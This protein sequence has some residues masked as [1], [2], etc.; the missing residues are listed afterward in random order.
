MYIRTFVPLVLMTV[1]LAVLPQQKAPTF[2]GAALYRAHCASC[3]GT[4][5]RGDGPVAEFLK[6]PPADLTQ[7]ASHDRGAF[8]AAQVQRVID[9][10]QLVRTHGDAKMP[11]WGDVFS[12]SLTHEDEAAVRQKIE[13]LVNY[14][15]SIQERHARTE[16][17]NLPQGCEISRTVPVSGATTS[18][19]SGV[20]AGA[21]GRR[22]LARRMPS[23]VVTTGS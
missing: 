5:G 4:S 13:A 3:H 11:V 23:R 7:I 22:T 17:R 19:N 14:L 20:I 2:D 21:S 6:V 15:R 9:G 12:Q 10:R 16:P 8:P 18:A 1:P